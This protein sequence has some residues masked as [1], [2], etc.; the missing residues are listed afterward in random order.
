MD[1][2]EEYDSRTNAYL[3]LPP[4]IRPT[5]PLEVALRTLKALPEQVV[6]I[7]RERSEPEIIQML[8]KWA[9]VVHDMGQVEIPVTGEHPRKCP[10][11]RNRD[12]RNDALAKFYTE[13]RVYFPDVYDKESTDN[14]I[15]R[16]E[17]IFDEGIREDDAVQW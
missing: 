4:T 6:S 10:H 13:L 5:L 3:A 7:T 9:C 8:Y 15:T 1:S 17:A 2:D 11:E 12:A 14:V 16:M